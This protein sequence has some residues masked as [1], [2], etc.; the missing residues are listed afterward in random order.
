M[1]MYKL[2]LTSLVTI[3]ILNIVHVEASVVLDSGNINAIKKTLWKIIG[4]T[5]NDTHRNTT[6]TTNMV[7]E[8]S[9]FSTIKRE[10]NP[11]DKATVTIQ[12]K[13]AGTYAA[14]S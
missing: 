4:M 8:H 13:K 14:I 12:A 2:L 6:N 3:H 10:L 5:L 11:I 7:I 1:K 9:S